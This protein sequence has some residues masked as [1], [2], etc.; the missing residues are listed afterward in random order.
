MAQG[1]LGEASFHTA[2]LSWA[3][4]HSADQRRVLVP[5]YPLYINVLV[6]HGCPLCYA[7]MIGFRPAENLPPDWPLEN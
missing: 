3:D 6:R 5:Y 2:D 1:N 4:L 7:R